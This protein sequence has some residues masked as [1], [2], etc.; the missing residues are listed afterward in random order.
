M[1][2]TLD[3]EI[4]YLKRS[5]IYL[6]ESLTAMNNAELAESAIREKIYRKRC[7]LMWL[8]DYKRLRKGSERDFSNG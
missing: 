8:E 2:M 3:E 4:A 6:N 5:I 1:N 7:L